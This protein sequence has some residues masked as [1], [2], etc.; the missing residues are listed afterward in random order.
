MNADAQLGD[1]WWEGLTALLLP[2]MQKAILDVLRAAD[3]PL[4][5]AELLLGI[6]DE[7][8]RVGRNIKHHLRRLKSL[9]A[10][11]VVVGENGKGP[12]RYRLT[13][14][15]GRGGEAANAGSREPEG[16]LVAAKFGER[17]KACRMPTGLSQEE[18]AHR[19]GIH[20]TEVS[21]LE[22]GRREPRLGTVVKLA[23]V[24]G[25]T[26]GELL[27]VTRWSAENGFEFGEGAD[28]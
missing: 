14:R 10:I 4:S 3:A 22:R 28:E 7:L 1:S 27:G 12:A 20:R 25:V 2:W 18:L 19:A 8:G 15:P 24:L 26:L 16:N 17:L 9:N 13:D 21:L 5:E 6:D 11:E 23:A